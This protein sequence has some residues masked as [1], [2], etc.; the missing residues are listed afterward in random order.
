MID[1]GLF[2]LFPCDEVYGLHNMPG[3]PQGHFGIRPGAQM[4]SSDYW[5]ITIEGRGGHAAFPHTCVDPV[6]AASQLVQSFQSIISR[7]LTP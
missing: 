6:I 5:D 1:E 3:I 4:A 7:T 2:E